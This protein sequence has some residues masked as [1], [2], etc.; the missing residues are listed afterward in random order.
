MTGAKMRVIDTLDREDANTLMMA[1][2]MESLQWQE[3]FQYS[4]NT[5]SLAWEPSALLRYFVSEPG[6]NL[7]SFVSGMVTGSRLAV[8]AV[9]PASGSGGLLHYYIASNG[10]E[11]YKRLQE[12]DT[13]E[14]VLRTLRSG[15]FRAVDDTTLPLTF[16]L[17]VDAP[18]TTVLLLDAYHEM[19]GEDSL[20]RRQISSI[21]FGVHGYDCKVSL[22]MAADV[23]VHFDH[24][25]PHMP[26][27]RL[28]WNHLTITMPYDAGAVHSASKIMKRARSMILEHLAASGKDMTPV[29]MD[30]G[31]AGRGS[32]RLQCRCT[33]CHNSSDTLRAAE[34]VRVA[35]TYKC[36]KCHNLERRLG[37]YKYEEGVIP[38]V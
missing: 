10:T 23:P 12:A 25:P 18:I 21:Q 29:V 1:A 32:K 26:M 27:I 37:D 14:A 16:D 3:G 15:D 33:D 30:L 19:M 9:Y 7:P 13:A 4:K 28:E 2:G 5:D 8:A 38:N 17:S 36:P 20:R 24:L 31:L 35:V 11:A 34:K 22:V 6:G